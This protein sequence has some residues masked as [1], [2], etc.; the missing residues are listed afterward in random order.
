[1]PASLRRPGSAVSPAAGPAA[2]HAPLFQDLAK[3]LDD[4]RRH[5]VLDLGA[6]STAMLALLGRARCRVEVADL[7]YFGGIEMLN[8]ADSRSSLLAAADSLVVQQPRDELF[9]LIFCWDLLNYLTL[10]AVSALMAAIAQNARP[11]AIVHALISY[12]DREMLD[13]PGRFIPTADGELMDHRTPGASVA[14][15]R[16]SPEN[17]QDNMRPFAID[18][19]RLLRNGMQEYQFRLAI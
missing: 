2:V 19:A 8:N 9:D 14:A 13:R 18:Y 4:N 11:G 17:L 12:S 10:D 7:A 6:A 1:M 15:P 3:R 5:V 16:Y